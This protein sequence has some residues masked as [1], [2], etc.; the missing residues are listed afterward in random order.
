[1]YYWKI[2]ILVSAL[3]IGIEIYLA[4]A[5]RAKSSTGLDRG[6]MKLMWIVIATSIGAGIYIAFSGYGFL[7]CCVK[8]L[9]VIGIVLIITGQIIR[10]VAILTLKRYFTTNVAIL[11]DHR[12][13]KTG[14]YKYVRH[15]AYSGDILS[16]FGLGLAFSSWLAFLVIFIPVL[17]SFLYRIKIEEEI[18]IKKFGKEYITYMQSTKRLIPWI[19]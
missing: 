9:S 16:F 4:A 11:P 12:L 14:I 18:L 19:V 13:I 7:S 15:P 17:L 3:W 1:M 2:F 8:T 6:S 5:R 10:G